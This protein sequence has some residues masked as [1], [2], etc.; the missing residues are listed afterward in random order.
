MKDWTGNSK[1]VEEPSSV[2]VELIGFYSTAPKDAVGKFY[3]HTNIDEFRQR[4]RAYFIY[5]NMISFKVL[6][7]IWR[8]PGQVFEILYDQSPNTD[9]MS[10]KW[11]CVRIIDDFESQNYYQHI[12]LT[13]ISDKVDYN[14]I[15]DFT[16]ELAMTVDKN[17]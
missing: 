11:M 10:G 6:G 13:R 3:R 1:S 4:L 17:N 14:A 5:K 8:E 7:K 2:F 12:F 9:K 15:A 16:D